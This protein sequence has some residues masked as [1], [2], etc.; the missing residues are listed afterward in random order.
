MMTPDQGTDIVRT[1]EAEAA[2][3]SLTERAAAAEA[4]A[5]QAEDLAKRAEQALA[6]EQDRARQAE[7]ERDAER[8]RAEGL[9]ALLEATRLQLAEQRVLMTDQALARAKTAQEANALRAA[10]AAARR[11]K[12]RWARL[13]AAW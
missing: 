12:G 10:E 13:K 6:V 8:S 5:E 11:S 4:R 2:V 3:S 1:L 9:S 7:Q